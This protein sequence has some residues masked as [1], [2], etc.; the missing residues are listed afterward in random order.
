MRPLE[1]VPAEPFVEERALQE[2]GDRGAAEKVTEL[3]EIEGWDVDELSLPVE[4]AFEEHGMAMR[5]RTGAA[6]WLRN[7]SPIPSATGARRLPHTGRGSFH[8]LLFG[9]RD[10]HQTPGEMNSSCGLLQ[11]VRPVEAFRQST[12]VSPSFIPAVSRRSS[13]MAALEWPASISAVQ[14]TFAPPSGAPGSLSVSFETP[15]PSGPR[16]RGPVEG[17]GQRRKAEA[18][19]GGEGKSDD[20]ACRYCFLLTSTQI[21]SPA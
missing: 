1:H 4:S 10:L 17:V 14:S 15:S 12:A 7:P 11:S 8:S 9:R 13:L 21:R 3:R 6:G 20:T 19:E 18:G 2:E 5:R 16:H